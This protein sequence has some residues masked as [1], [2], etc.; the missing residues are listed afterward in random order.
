MTTMLT[1]I[2]RLR[3]LR[4]QQRDLNYKI[5]QITTEKSNIAFTGNTYMQ[6]GT[7]Y[8]PE[9]PM[10]KVMQD[11]QAKLK[12]LEDQLDQQMESY[13]IQLK[14][15]EAEYDACKQRLDAEIKEEMSYSL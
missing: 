6:V 10:M 1:D 14:M 15:V 8:D 3:Q 13:Q 2:M 4:G 12:I 5:Q 9:S 7:D 11:R